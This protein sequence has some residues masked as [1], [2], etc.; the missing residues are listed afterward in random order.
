MYLEFKRPA[1]FEYKSGQWLRISCEALGSNEY[2]PFTL[3]SAPHEDTL[4]IHVRSLGAWSWGLR[5]AYDLENLKN[6][7]FP[8][9]GFKGE[10]ALVTSD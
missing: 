7:P 2:H 1:T 8:K 5:T 3:T 4:G 10:L 9:V 6:E